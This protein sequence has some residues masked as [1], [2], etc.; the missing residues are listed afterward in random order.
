VLE[1]LKHPQYWSSAQGD[2]YLQLDALSRQMNIRH[3]AWMQDVLDLNW[4]AI[5]ANLF[6]GR[7]MREREDRARLGVYYL[8]DWVAEQQI[9]SF[10]QL[11]RDSHTLPIT[12]SDN[13]DVIDDVA[14]NLVRVLV[15]NRY[16]K[17][18]DAEYR[19][20]WDRA[21]PPAP[22]EVSVEISSSPSRTQKLKIPQP[23]GLTT[24]TAAGGN[25]NAALRQADRSELTKLRQILSHRF[26]EEELRTFCIDL[27]LDYESLAGRGKDGKA[28]EI[29][30]Y[31]NRRHQVR[32]IIEI[33]QR[34]RPDIRW[35]DIL[36]AG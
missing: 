11:V 35:D 7:E 12:I 5:R 8:L 30:E 33:G 36:G 19:V 2:F 21:S 3:N 13:P 4:S 29:V 6:A 15:G 20:V 10:E 34:Q 16:L 9:F 18:V 24:D 32:R 23:D 26:D 17:L 14:W 25:D 1:E 22:R 27:G 31:L 28:R